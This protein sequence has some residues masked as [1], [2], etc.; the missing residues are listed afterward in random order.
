MADLS[1]S[2]PEVEDPPVLRAVQV[3]PEEEDTKSVYRA[4][5]TG[6]VSLLLI[7][8]MLMRSVI[9]RGRGWER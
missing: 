5:D 2:P 8:M 6:G 9:G 3:A 4:T 7:A 1:P